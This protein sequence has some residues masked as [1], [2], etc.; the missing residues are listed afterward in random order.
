[1][2]RVVQTAAWD[3]LG[4]PS[5]EGVPAPSPPATTVPAAS[6]PPST[7]A[8]V[9]PGPAL[10]PLS[11]VAA[12]PP[13]RLRRMARRRGAPRLICP[14]ARPRFNRR[15]CLARSPM[16]HRSRR[17]VS[18][19][20]C[21]TSNEHWIISGHAGRPLTQGMPKHKTCPKGNVIGGQFLAFTQHWIATCVSFTPSCMIGDPLMGSGLGG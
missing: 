11:A 16:W 20:L 17:C 18:F 7:P 2:L 9:P 4:A 10:A 1:M 5:H 3:R 21:H 6:C 19:Y 12:P 14:M 8:V 13:P 15:R